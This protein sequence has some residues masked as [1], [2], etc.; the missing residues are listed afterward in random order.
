MG[1][2]LVVGG[3]VLLVLAAGAAVWLYARLAAT[4]VRLLQHV[5]VAAPELTVRSLTP[6]GFVAVVLGSDVTV[7]LATLARRRPRGMPEGEWFDKLLEGI[8]AQA[9]VPQVPPYALVRDRV[10]PL[11]K[12]EAYARLFEHYRTPLWLA[13]RPLAGGIV[14]T[15]VIAGRHQRTVISAGALKT[16]E[17]DVET[18]HT[19]A[20]TN[21]RAQ[22]AHLLDEIGGRRTRY[23]HLDGADATRILVADLIVPPEIVDPVIAIPEETTLLIAPGG[24]RAALVVEAAARYAAS[25]RPISPLLFRASPLGPVPI[26]EPSS[27]RPDRPT[28]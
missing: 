15:Y 11:L 14:I 26:E 18:L 5:R 22:T 16:W 3:L 1:E 20:V 27:P 7:D 9:P 6:V 8:R 24:E 10:L 19:Q 28:G 12:P 13:W 21:L 4:R 17:I 23:E 2:F 25:T